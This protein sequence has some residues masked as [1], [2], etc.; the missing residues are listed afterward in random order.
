LK[1]E[2]KGEAPDSNWVEAGAWFK[3]FVNLG[4]QLAEAT[5]SPNF[6]INKILVA[7]PKREFVSAALAFGYSIQK[8]RS[9]QTLLQNVGLEA[10]FEL[11]TGQILRIERKPGLGSSDLHIQDVALESVTSANSSE[12]TSVRITIQAN[13]SQT[14]FM[15]L[16]R[17][18]IASLSV[19]PKGFPTGLH[20]LP[21]P[22]AGKLSQEVPAIRWNSQ[23]SPG[24]VIYG[25]VDYFREQASTGVRYAP[26]Q[27]VLGT[28][29]TILEDMGRIDYAENKFPHFVNLFEPVNSFPKLSD[30][31]HSLPDLCEWIVLDG[32]RAST[33]LSAKEALIDRRV[34]SIVEMGVPRSQGKALAAFTEQTANL[35]RVDASTLL[36]WTPPAGV[37]I[38]AWSNK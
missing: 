8:F 35:R 37:Q 30:W 31:P 5:A 32:N 9:G 6:H 38:W 13:G 26:M 19:L 14:P 3:S 2:L 11:E 33:K 7:C 1:I 15:V 10:V 16:E 25:E 23:A 20:K 27:A 12:V 21:V 29:E 18:R 22:P 4:V 17:S 34:L 28:S 24:L 36:A